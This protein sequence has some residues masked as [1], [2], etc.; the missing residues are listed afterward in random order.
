MFDEFYAPLA[1]K[2]VWTVLP[3]LLRPKSVGVIKLRSKDIY[4]Y[5]LIYP[6]YLTHPLDTATL[7]EGKNDSA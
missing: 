3:M 4:E 5:P 2:D 1:N 6:N 7:V